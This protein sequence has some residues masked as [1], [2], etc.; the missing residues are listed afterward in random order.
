MERIHPESLVFGDEVRVIAPSRSL[1]VIS[2]ENRFIA[3]DHFRELGIQISYSKN[4]EEIDDFTS[5]SID[6]RIED[7]HEAFSNKNVKG[8]LTVIGGFNSNQLLRYID[9]KIIGKNPKVLC[10][11]SDVTTLNNSIFTKTGLVTYSG[12]HYSTFSQ[13]LYLDYTLDYFKKCLFSKD[14]FKVEPSKTWSD[15]DW[16]KN[17]EERNLIG[18]RGWFVINSGIAEGTIL[19]GNLSTFNLLQGTEYFPDMDNSILFLEDYEGTNP[20]IFDRATIF[21]SFT[22]F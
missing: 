2:R 5:S 3:N 16:Y 21:D 8:I 6:S 13:K 11:F 22:Q 18:N 9:W 19:G 12:P 4:A 14:S 15:D 10:G 1:A 7:M 20:E 17:Q